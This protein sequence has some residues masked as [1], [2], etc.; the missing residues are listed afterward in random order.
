VELS[1]TRV[2]LTVLAVTIA[3]NVA[4]GFGRITGYKRGLW[5]GVHICERHR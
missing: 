5:Q 2:L 4:Y 3:L 1:V